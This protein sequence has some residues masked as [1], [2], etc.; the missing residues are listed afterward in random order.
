MDLF[1][2]LARLS[3]TIALAMGLG[4]A[5][6]ARAS[7]EAHAPSQVFLL[8]GDQSL[9]GPNCLSAHVDEHGVPIKRV[10]I[11]ACGDCLFAFSLQWVA[12][13]PMTVLLRLQAPKRLTFDPQRST[14][15]G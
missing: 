13:P 10:H 5:S 2:K 3:L 4:M 6:V 15:G 8:D 1:S 12:T 14:G 9:F 11:H 7:H